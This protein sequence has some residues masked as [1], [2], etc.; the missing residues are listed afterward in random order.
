MEKTNKIN[1]LQ[2]LLSIALAVILWA[3]AISDA[4]PMIYQTYRSVNV[5]LRNENKVTDRG[6][7]IVDDKNITVSVRLH[8]RTKELNKISKDQIVAYLDL[9]GATSSGKFVGEVFVEGISSNIEVIEISPKYIT[10][11]IAQVS[12]NDFKPAFETEGDPGEDHSV[13]GITSNKEYVSISGSQDSVAQVSSVKGI[14]HLSGQKADFSQTVVLNAYNNKG[15]IIY[16]VSVNPSSINAQVS[17]GMNKSV[18]LTVTFKG[19][20]PDGCELGELSILPASVVVA[21]KA[22]DLKEVDVLNLGEINLTG[23]ESSFSL[24]MSATLPKGIILTE[25][26]NFFKVNVEILGNAE[27]T[28]DV[29]SITLN[30]VPTE[31]SAQVI[32]PDEVAVTL[33]GSE[34]VIKQIKASDITLY[35][36]LKGLEAGVHTVNL[37]YKLPQSVKLKK[38]SAAK[39]EVEIK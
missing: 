31:L 4:D 20:L 33:V 39:V 26:E 11:N 28:F 10:F 13:I 2:I 32:S 36:N 18:P 37:Q 1:I 25:E 23:K 35:A 6:L 24:N 3:F 27:K 21:G 22:E 17:M 14:V 19:K 16:D 7:M 5:Q 30:N 12:S 38:I 9:K 8:G 29:S 15:D 34:K